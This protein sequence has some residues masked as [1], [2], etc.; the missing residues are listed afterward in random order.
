MAKAT[1][2]VKETG[3]GTSAHIRCSEAEYKAW[4]VAA[5]LDGFSF[6]NWARFRCNGDSRA[7]APDLRPAKAGKR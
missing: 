2:E 3:R 4:Q 1:R 7:T 6:S 5:K